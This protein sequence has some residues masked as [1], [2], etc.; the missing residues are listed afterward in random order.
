MKRG[1][2]T[3]RI[4]NIE[5]AQ[6]I[7]VRRDCFKGRLCRAFGEGKMLGNL[8]T[9][10]EKKKRAAWRSFLRFTNRKKREAQ[11]KRKR[12]RGGVKSRDITIGC[13]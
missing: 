8:Q 1:R 9:M 2:Q 6:K 11:R 5:W 4:K 3:R 10:G 13:G 7:T 12:T